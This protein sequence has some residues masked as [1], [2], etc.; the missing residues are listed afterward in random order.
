MREQASESLG[1]ALSRARTDR[2]RDFRGSELASGLPSA[3]GV[4]A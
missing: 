2:Q 3:G 1:A 4:V